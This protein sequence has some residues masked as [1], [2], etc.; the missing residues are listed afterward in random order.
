MYISDASCKYPYLMTFNLF[1]KHLYCCSRQ[2]H[3]LPLSLDIAA[4]V[5]IFKRKCPAFRTTSEY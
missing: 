4:P 3:S 1:L 5:V 2:G